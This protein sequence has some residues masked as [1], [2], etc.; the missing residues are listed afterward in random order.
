MFIEWI[1]ER[2]NFTNKTSNSFISNMGWDYIQVV[3][4]INNKTFEIL[5]KY[6]IRKENDIKYIWREIKAHLRKQC[7]V[8]INNNITRI[9]RY[10]CEHCLF[11]SKYSLHIEYR[12]N[13]ENISCPECNTRISNKF[14]RDYE[15]NYYHV[16]CFNRNPDVFKNKK[17][18]LFQCKMCNKYVNI[19]G[20]YIQSSDISNKQNIYNML[21]K[22]DIVT[23]QTFLNETNNYTLFLRLSELE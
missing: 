9:L 18:L 3:I 23:S 16:K 20:Y 11:N 22:A 4:Q 10:K 17:N 2:Y 14:I 5:V 19:G 7:D 12:I 13:N 15:N 1:G 21:Q 8:Y 6:Y